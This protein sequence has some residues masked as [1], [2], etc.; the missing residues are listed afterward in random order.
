MELKSI[1]GNYFELLGIK[2]A[3]FPDEQVLRRQ[4]Y[5]NSRKFH[6]DHAD[7]GDR[8]DAEEKM[9]LSGLNNEAYRVLSDFDFRAEYIVKHFSDVADISA[10]RLPA[11]FLMEM[12][13]LN[14]QIDEY[15]NA[16]NQEGL[17]EVLSV[18]DELEKE[19]FDSVQSSMKKFDAATGHQNADET[20]IFYFLKK[21][22]LLR[23]RESLTN[24]AA[25]TM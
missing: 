8:Q 20:L 17:R 7:A 22:Y 18:V 11:G 12:M 5:L 15:K 4:Y 23:I 3:F 13:E 25:P 1:Y 9:F 24:F 10:V 19:L 16:D 2:P 14:E 6:P 21:K